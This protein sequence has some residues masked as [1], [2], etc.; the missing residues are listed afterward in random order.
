MNAMTDEK[1]IW[2]R[3]S[4]DV[5]GRLQHPE[6]NCAV[7]CLDFSSHGVRLISPFPMQVGEFAKLAVHATQ[8]DITDFHAKIQCQRCEPLDGEWIIGAH[9]IDIQ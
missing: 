1:R 8:D 7:R 6:G 5:P 4:I 9:V 2:S 3:L